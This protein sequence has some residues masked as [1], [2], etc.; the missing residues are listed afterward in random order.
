MISFTS[1]KNVPAYSG[2]QGEGA[3][4]PRASLCKDRIALTA[5]Q[6]GGGQ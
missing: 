2:N 3:I 5:S 6:I 1:V 4:S